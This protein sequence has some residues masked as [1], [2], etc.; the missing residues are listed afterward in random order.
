MDEITGSKWDELTRL[1]EE[2]AELKRKNDVMKELC[3]TLLAHITNSDLQTPALLQGKEDYV[4]KQVLGPSGLV[5]P[6]KNKSAR[7]LIKAG[8]FVA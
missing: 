3:E 5:N 6:Q 8:R 1:R 7:R 2:N 4:G